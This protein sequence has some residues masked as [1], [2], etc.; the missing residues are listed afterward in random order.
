MKRVFLFGQG[1]FVF[2]SGVFF[3]WER[4]VFGARVFFLMRVI[5]ILSVFFFLEE[6]VFFRVFFFFKKVFL[7]F[8][9]CVCVF[10]RFFLSGGWF[11]WRRRCFI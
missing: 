8:E 2:C 4:F 6:R 11:F 7:F 10:F 9:D 5:F 1:G 3:F